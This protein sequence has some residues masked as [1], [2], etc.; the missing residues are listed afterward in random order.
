M[1]IAIGLA[2][3][4]SGASMTHA[5]E[6]IEPDLAPAAP[7]TQPA[8][9]PASAPPVVEKPA[10]KSPMFPL[11]GDKVRAAGFELPPRGG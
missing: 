11:W 6:P 1:I 7:P 2:V 3:S 5:E 4:L 9:V 10:A 8:T